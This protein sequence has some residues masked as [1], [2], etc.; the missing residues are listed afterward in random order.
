MSVFL[1]SYS[2]E[3]LMPVGI[4]KPKKN[5]AELAGWLSNS[6][7]IKNVFDI[8][9]IVRTTFLNNQ[10]NGKFLTQ[11]YCESSLWKSNSCLDNCPHKYL[12][13]YLPSRNKT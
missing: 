8:I 9:L 3:A 7:N 11:C 1:N 10:F 4:P 13:D 5:I 12:P 2:C 6:K